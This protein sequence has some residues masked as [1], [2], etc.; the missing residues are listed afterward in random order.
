M[1]R[2]D[3]RRRAAISRLMSINARGIEKS[4]PGPDGPITVLAGVDI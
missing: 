1:G 2:I 4:F 3:P